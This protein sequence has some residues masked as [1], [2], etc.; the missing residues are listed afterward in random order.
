MELRKKNEGSS[1]VQVGKQPSDKLTTIRLMGD[2]SYIRKG[3][4]N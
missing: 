3:H 4:Q 1:D 2:E